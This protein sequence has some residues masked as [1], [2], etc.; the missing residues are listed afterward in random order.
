MGTYGIHTTRSLLIRSC[1]A[2]AALAAILGVRA[3]AAN[4]GLLGMRAAAHQSGAP[5]ASA[6]YDTL[7]RFKGSPID[8]ATPIANPIFF[9]GNLF[10]VT[11]KGGSAGYGTVFEISPSGVE[12]TLHNF[13]DN[14]DAANPA[15]ALVPANGLL[16]GTATSGGT[17]GEG[18]VYTIDPILGT[19][20][21]IHSFG[22]ID[23]GCPFTND[24]IYPYAGLLQ[25]G[26]TFYGTT[27]VGGA[28]YVGTVFSISPTGS[29]TT[30]YSFGS[31]P[32]DG[33]LPYGTLINVGGTLF[34]TTARGGLHGHGSIY[35]ISPAGVEH[36]IYSFPNDKKTGMDPYG[37][38]LNLDGVLYGT[39]RDGG[40]FGLGTIFAVTTAGAER[41][42]HSFATTDGAN[43][44]GNLVAHNGLL[45]GSTF[46]GGDTLGYG[47]I[48]SMTTAGRES[49]LHTFTGISD[50]AHPG[51]GLL[52]TNS[53]IIGATEGG[54]GFYGSLFQI[55]F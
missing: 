11:F 9:D 43:P 54:V 16:Y 50:G 8:G 37:A 19:E 24:G 30:L 10:G 3:Q 47:T 46:Y 42:V 39:T 35:A 26:T 25:V 32:G 53:A 29:E 13:T 31:A 22:S 14:G 23:G 20:R 45:Y 4:R 17:C 51:G 55:S 49:I 2:I 41:V 15:S 36:V 34:G 38:L 48:F 52:S 1:C 7:Y 33:Q 28:N 18:A 6:T 21:L 12:K 40:A 44:Y 27:K 5:L